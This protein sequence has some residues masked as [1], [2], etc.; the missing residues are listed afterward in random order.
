MRLNGATFEQAG[1]CVLRCN[2]TKQTFILRL[3]SNCICGEHQVS[4]KWFVFIVPQ[5]MHH[6]YHSTYYRG[7]SNLYV[8][9]SVMPSFKNLQ[10]VEFTALHI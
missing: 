1:T 8:Y 10:T 5:L 6:K 7:Y 2:H 9:M 4:V 3:E